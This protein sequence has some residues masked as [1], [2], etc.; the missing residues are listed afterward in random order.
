M[1]RIGPLFASISQSVADP[2]PSF[3]R[4]A[5]TV[6]Q[7]L[8]AGDK[9]AAES[10]LLTA[11]ARKEFGSVAIASLRDVRGLA[12]LYQS[13]VAGRG[14]VRLGHPIE[15]VVHYRMETE[16]GQRWLLVHVDGAGLVADFDVVDN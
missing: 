14:L 11:G 9:R 5:L 10:P 6:V 7:M 13:N 15:K 8:A 16:R 1:P 3:T 12:F 2:D 4:T